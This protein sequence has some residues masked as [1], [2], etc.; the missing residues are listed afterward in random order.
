MHK[1]VICQDSCFPGRLDGRAG[2]ATSAGLSHL[3]SRTGTRLREATSQPPSTIC[4]WPSRSRARLGIVS[5]HQKAQSE[6]C[7]EPTVRWP[8]GSPRRGWR[9]LLAKRRHRMAW[10]DCGAML[11]RT[12]EQPA[13]R[14][15]CMCMSMT[16]SACV[17]VQACM[18][19]R[20]LPVVGHG[21]TPSS[22]KMLGHSWASR[23]SHWAHRL[24]AGPGW[25]H[26]DRHKKADGSPS[27]AVTL[28][29][30]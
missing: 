29:W 16:R 10:L 19:A 13:P 27:M 2:P 30:N 7:P 15:R 14:Y 1:S 17:C 26:K 22:G 24:C 28:Y 20:E 8:Q 11:G 6:D 21:Q 25:Q 4:L 3:S 12:A 5:L 9:L 18:R 23:L